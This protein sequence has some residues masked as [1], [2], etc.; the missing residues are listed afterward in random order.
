MAED[1]LYKI[2]TLEG[3]AMV[4]AAT[5]REPFGPAFSS[6][7]IGGAVRME[8]WGTLFSHPEEFVVYKLFDETNS[9]IAERQVEGY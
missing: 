4:K 9:L 3:E 5:R 1:G 8:I 6:E 2:E 7:E